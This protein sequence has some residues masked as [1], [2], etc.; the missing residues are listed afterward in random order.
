MKKDLLSIN[1][2]SRQEIEAL[3]DL[4]DFM[5]KIEPETPRDSMNKWLL[6]MH[7]A[8]KV[9]AKMF[10][11]PSTSTTSS[12]ELAMLNLR[13]KV[14]GFNSPEVSAV[15]KG[16]SLS[17]TARIYDGYIKRS[18]GGLI[19]VRHP[20]AGAAEIVAECAESPVINAGDGDNEHPSQ[21]LVDLYTIQKRRGAIDGLIVGIW[22]D[23]K[24]SRVARSLMLGLNKFNDIEFFLKAPS[25]LWTDAYFLEQIQHE[26][27]LGLMGIF[28]ELDV[29]YV[30]R[31]KKERFEDPKDYEAVMSSYCV[32]P[33]LMEQCKESMLLMHPLPRVDEIAKEVDKD[34]RAVY[35]EQA[36][37][38][39]PVRMALI[40]TL[41]GTSLEALENS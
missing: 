30:V 36:A 15:S 28:P 13:G 21:A 41:L 26:V 31:I 12:F 8:D 18:G 16:E 32:T 39:I 3:F 33:E 40:A 29:L 10:F 25:E 7:C 6:E 35:F 2:I 4:A 23:L 22:G 34:P 19:V 37:N 14:V 38:G 5:A 9:L 24:H 20:Q 27:H 11:E 1:D 17:D